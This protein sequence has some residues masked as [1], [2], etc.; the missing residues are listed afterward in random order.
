RL[1]ISAGEALPAQTYQRWLHRFGGPIIDGMGTTELLPMC[2]SNRP[3]AV[4]PRSSGLPLPR[5]DVW[6]V[7]ESGGPLAPGGVARPR[8]RGD[9]IMAAYWNQPEKTARSLDG[10]WLLTGDKYTQDAD[11][12]F[13]YCG[14]S[15]DMLKVGGIWV[16]PF[17]VEAT[18]VAHPAVL[19]S[20]VV[21]QED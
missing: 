17:E 7:A 3:G 10:E 14:R 19:E 6:V 12:Y 11:G 4:R 2:L 8:V 20:A 16:S 13:W 5:P 21:G 9:S 18:L 1:C 15:D